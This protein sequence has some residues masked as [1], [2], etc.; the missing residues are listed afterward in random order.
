LHESRHAPALHVSVPFAGEDWQ[1]FA[2][3]PQWARSVLVSTSHPSDAS[4]LQ[5]NHGAMHA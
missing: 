2:Q 4:P 5:S 3:P 1:T